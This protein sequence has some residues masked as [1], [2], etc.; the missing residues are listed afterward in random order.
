MA[1]DRRVR[2]TQ[3]AIKKAFIQLLKQK[4]LDHITI[5]DITEVADI[6]R[7][8]FYLHYEDK[9]DLLEKMEDEYA[10][11]LYDKT[12]IFESMKTIES[13]DK[14]Y[15]VFSNQVLRNVITHVYN[16]LEFYQ[17]ILTIE[18]QSQIEERISEMILENMK[19]R[20]NPKGDIA[21]V[22]VMYF[23]SYVSGSM[24]SV[25]KY[26]VQDEQRVDID[27]LIQYISKIVFNGPLRLLATD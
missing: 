26:W 10:N 3:S 13:I 15:E 7:G 14:F 21:G 12:R 18:R 5:H 8:T 2:K 25:I 17:V 16:N 1:V 23:H 19:L 20:M 22:P 24:L 6:N 9:Y 27:T 11:V 4:D